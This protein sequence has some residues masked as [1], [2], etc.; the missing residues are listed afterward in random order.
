MHIAKPLSQKLKKLKIKN[1]KCEDKKMC[2]RL[3]FYGISMGDDYI[4]SDTKIFKNSKKVTIS[5]IYKPIK[6]YYVSK[7]HTL[8]K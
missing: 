7:L 8:G 2:K 5:Y 3:K 6:V 1:L 4:L